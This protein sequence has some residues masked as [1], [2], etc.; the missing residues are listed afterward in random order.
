METQEI[1][2]PADE[3]VEVVEVVRR[4]GCSGCGILVGRVAAEATVARERARRGRDG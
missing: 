1:I 2:W 3:A 4:S